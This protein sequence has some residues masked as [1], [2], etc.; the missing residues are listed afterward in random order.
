M[1]AAK[2]LP[3][4]CMYFGYCTSRAVHALWA[5]LVLQ[6]WAVMPSADAGGDSFVVLEYISLSCGVTACDVE[7][8]KEQPSTVVRGSDSPSR[9]LRHLCRRPQGVMLL[10]YHGIHGR[11]TR[12][13]LKAPISEAISTPVHHMGC[14]WADEPIQCIPGGKASL[15][16]RST[17]LLEASEMSLPRKETS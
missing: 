9:S 10:C 13:V 1:P 4:L 14:T 11:S 5:V 2:L 7:Y 15:T 6:L 16:R 17:T 8:C 3:L 12:C